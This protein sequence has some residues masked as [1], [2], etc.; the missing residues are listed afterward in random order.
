MGALCFWEIIMSMDKSSKQYLKDEARAEREKQ[1]RREKRAR[2]KAKQQARKAAGK[3]SRDLSE[4]SSSGSETSSS[5]E[6]SDRSN[7]S[8][9]STPQRRTGGHGVGAVSSG[10]PEFKIV[11]G[12]HH[13]KSQAGKW[14]DCSAPPSKPFERC[15]QRHWWHERKEFNC[16]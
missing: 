2:K 6:S 3:K 4:S 11:N 15:G 7:S 13:F 16:S 5:E 8:S 14:V 1:K 12:K 10:V 9:E